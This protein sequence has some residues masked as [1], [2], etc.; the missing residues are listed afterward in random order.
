MKGVKQKRNET[1]TAIII[2]GEE[3]ENKYGV[4]KPI[5]I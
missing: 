1:E 3:N 4:A 2:N 5:P